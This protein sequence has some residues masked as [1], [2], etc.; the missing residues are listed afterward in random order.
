VNGW[1]RSFAASNRGEEASREALCT[2]G[3][4]YLA[5]RGAAP[6][7]QTDGVHYPG[8]YAAGCYNRLADA[9]GGIRVENESIVNLPNWLMFRFRVEDGPWLGAASVTMIDDDYDLDLRHGTLVRRFTVADEAGRHTQVSQQRFVHM[10]RRHVCGLRTTIT[11]VNW[12]GQLTIHSGVDARVLN[13]GVARYRELSGRHL[14]LQALTK[15]GHGVLCEVQTNQSRIRICVAA[16]T[17]VARRPAYAT[18]NERTVVHD[19]NIAQELDVRLS[20]GEQ[21]QVDK[22][23]TVATSKDLAISEPASAAVTMLAALPDFDELREE[24]AI[25]WSQLWQRYNLLLSGEGQRALHNIRLHL[26]HVLQ[27]ISVHSADTDGGVPAR[28]L[29]GEA[30]RGHVLWDELFVLP[31]LNLHHP[32][33]SRSMLSYRY[34]RLPAACGA[35]KAVGLS[36]AMFP[37]QSGSDGREESQRLHLNPLSGRWTTDETF[38]QRHVGLAVA[39]NVWQ[40]F[41]ATADWQFLD[42]YGAEVILQVARFFAGLAEFDHPRGRYVIR[43]VVGPDEFHT[44]YPD[45]PPRGV[46]NN[47]YTN[48]MAAWLLLRARETLT[49]VSPRRRRELF[50]LLGIEPGELARWEDIS[51]RMYVPIHAD[52]VISQFEGYE[53]LAEFD[54]PGYRARYGD[55]RRLDRILEAEGEDINRFRVSKQA[56]VLMLFYLLSADEL[57]EVLGHCGYALGADIIPRTIDFYR[58]RTTHGSTLSSVVHAWVLARSRRREALQYFVETLESDVADVHGGTTGEG[59]HLAAMAGTIDLLERCFAGVELRGGTLH[60][61]P[62]WPPELGRLEFDIR[63]RSH[64]LHISVKADGVRLRCPPSEHRPIT[65]SC[66]GSVVELRP[67]EVIEF[68]EGTR[69]RRL[70]GNVTD[71]TPAENPDGSGRLLGRT[72]G[73]GRYN[74]HRAM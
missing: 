45:A 51:E 50:N 31:V 72:G 10:R 67:G 53:S 3:N 32:L 17:W 41:Q 35:A 11:A 47:A 21:V 18:V 24:H 55:I 4:G 64:Q 60:L 30:Y 63:Y 66:R 44:G 29:H 6:E 27:T 56:D 38:R 2:L 54:W 8:T 33:L 74:G 69:W 9:V 15:T 26:F 23:V 5:T 65:V 1:V 71:P 70:A 40:Y 14:D 46:D 58:R 61:N 57:R 36:G 48:V 19:E 28:G 62:Y 12:S 39:Y 59:I 25:A 22:L 16:C 20:A 34:R 37:W 68:T 49:A 42:D 73:R 7:S 43:G 52:G 13:E